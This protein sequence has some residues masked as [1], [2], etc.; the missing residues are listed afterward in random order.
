MV[1]S[2]SGEESQRKKG[3]SGDLDR[4]YISSLNT[5]PPGHAALLFW[6]GAWNWS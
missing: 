4:Y 2:S 6:T 1:G 3:K 5:K